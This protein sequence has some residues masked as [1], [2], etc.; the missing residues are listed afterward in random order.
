M[1]YMDKRCLKHDLDITVDTW[2][3]LFYF[4][5]SQNIFVPWVYVKIK[6][7]ACHSLLQESSKAIP[8]I[9]LTA[10]APGCDIPLCGG[11]SLDLWKMSLPLAKA[12]KIVVEVGKISVKVASKDQQEKEKRKLKVVKK[13][14][15][16]PLIWEDRDIRFDIDAA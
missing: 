15:N 16:K 7:C 5:L 1:T 6:Q 11:F 12:G 13:P 9:Q 10:F 3:Y 14:K 4:K 2:K 8:A